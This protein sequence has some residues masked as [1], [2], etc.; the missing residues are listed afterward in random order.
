MD[1]L[2]V[3]VEV[4]DAVVSK[5]DSIPV[6]WLLVAWPG[7]LAAAIRLMGTQ[8]SCPCCGRSG[9]VVRAIDA[10]AWHQARHLR[11]SG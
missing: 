10:A 4:A 9:P 2:P 6:Q 3:P 8:L 7:L 11:F 5:P 1:G